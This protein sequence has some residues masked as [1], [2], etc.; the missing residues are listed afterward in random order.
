MK[1]YWILAGI[2][3]M[4]AAGV[5]A[6]RAFAALTDK[7]MSLS[8]IEAVYV[9]VQGLT[10]ETKEAGLTQE[11][12][13][14][15]VEGKLKL[16]GIRAVSEEESLKVAGSPVLYV[17]ISAPKR[18]RT[19]A[20]VYHIDVGILQKVSLVREPKIRTMSITWNKGRLGY[21]PAK[22]LVESVRETVG[23]LMDE[24]AAD[25][26]AANP[27]QPVTEKSSI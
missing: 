22:S 12:I 27:K 24:F 2:S 9:F 26:R 17:N 23:Y 7:Q 4:C 6:A 18:K 10:D 25:Y 16:E 11:Q 13:Q 21:C 19:E 20:F 5:L 15:D 8:G 14:S 3:A 1:K